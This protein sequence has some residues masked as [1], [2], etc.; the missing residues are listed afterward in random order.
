MFRNTF[1]IIG[2][3][4]SFFWPPFSTS[5]PSGRTNQHRFKPY[6]LNTTLGWGKYPVPFKRDESQTIIYYTE[7]RMPCFTTR[8]KSKQ[9]HAY[10][11]HAWGWH[12]VTTI[13]MCS[14]SN[15]SAAFG[16]ALISVT[17]GLW[18]QNRISLPPSIVPL[19]VWQNPIFINKNKQ[20]N[21]FLFL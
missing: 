3:K 11:G 1:F 14:V 12:W 4:T 21:R 20:F 8:S 17:N 5:L 19:V 9:L 10:Y 13:R 16:S 18:N 15:S 7:S 2:F 6:F